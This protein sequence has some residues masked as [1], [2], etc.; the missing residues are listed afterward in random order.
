MGRWRKDQIRLLSL[1]LSLN[2]EFNLNQSRGRFALKNEVLDRH[3]LLPV[4]FHSSQGLP[5]RADSVVP[6]L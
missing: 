1:K 2:L 6:K 4:S 3:L 5:D